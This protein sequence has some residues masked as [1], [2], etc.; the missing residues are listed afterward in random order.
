MKLRMKKLSKIWDRN[1]V[2]DTLYAVGYDPLT[3]LI[4]VAR[5]MDSMNV[6]DDRISQEL[7]YKANLTL[8]EYLVPKPK[9]IEISASKN[10][11]EDAKTAMMKTLIALVEANR[12]EY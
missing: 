8:M 2:I 9:P 5:G 10:D 4:H 11:Q 3:A 12:K 7:R 6:E 1:R